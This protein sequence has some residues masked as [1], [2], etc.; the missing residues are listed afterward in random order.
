M[1][2][3]VSRSGFLRL[4]LALLLLCGIAVNDASAQG[5]GFGGRRFG[6]GGGGLQMLNIPEVQK[7]LK[8][9]PEQVG[10]LSAQ[11]DKVR[12][13][14][15]SLIESGGGGNPGQMSPEQRQAFM[16][17]VQ[18]LQSAAAAEVLDATQLKR[19]RELELQQ[20][21]GNAIARKDVSDA[22][23]LT[24][25]QKK[26]VAEV[27]VKTDAERR[28]AREGL[29]FQSMSDTERAT[30]RTKTQAID[31]AAGEKMVALLTDEQ[32]TQWKEMQGAPFTFPAPAAR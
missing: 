24:D 16:D 12:Q 30:L 9:T 31:K 11:Q 7:E 3:A 19:F 25:D 2:S 8:M 6:G 4:A 22:L 18:V 21:G 26:K 10:K 23:K 14:M 15:Q 32:K 28:A 20:I 5:G 13:G 1:R 17:K 27:L 29:D